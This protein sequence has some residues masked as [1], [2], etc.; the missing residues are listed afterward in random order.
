[1]ANKKIV[2][3]MNKEMDRKGFL[4][5]GMGV[6]LAMIGITGLMNTLMQLG[7]DSHSE[8]SV[9]EGYGASPYGR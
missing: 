8:K 6:M 4:K 5:Y 2:S 9:S 3:L 1:V 7:S